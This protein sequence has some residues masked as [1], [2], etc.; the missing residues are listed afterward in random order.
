MSSWSRGW[1]ENLWRHRLCP[2]HTWNILKLVFKTEMSP[3]QPSEQLER[4]LGRDWLAEAVDWPTNPRVHV[5]SS[6]WPAQPLDRKI[7]PGSTHQGN[8]AAESQPML[9]GT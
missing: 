1:E 7:A 8:I 2:L 6:M 4:G 5:Y 3:G 9:K